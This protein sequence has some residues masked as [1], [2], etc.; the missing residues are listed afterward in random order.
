[1]DSGNHVDTYVPPFEIFS[2]VLS[3][4]LEGKKVTTRAIGVKC[5]A[6]HNALFRK[7]FLKLFTNPPSAIAH[8]QFSLS[9]ITTVIGLVEYQNL[10]R[11]NNKHFNNLVTIPMAGITNRHL[12]LDIHMHDPQNPICRMTIC[13]IILENEWCSTIETTHTDGRLLITTTK[14][15]LAEA[16]KWLDESLKPLFT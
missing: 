5:N 3:T 14:M 6:P 2:M 15:H 12:D 13:E 10:I 1:M 8:I 7:L 11:D 9:G 4:T 16:R